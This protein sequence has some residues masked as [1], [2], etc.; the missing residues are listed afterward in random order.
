F[1]TVELRSDVA[2]AVLDGQLHAHRGAVVEGA[3]HVIRVQ[4]L[5]VRRDVDLTGGHR[6]GAGGAQGHA[7]RPFGVHAQGQLLDVQD[8]VDDV[9]PH[10]FQRG[11]FVDDAVDLDGGH[12][13]AL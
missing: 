13:R 2:L 6:A 4:H 1:R 8:D 12:R 3:D 5:D 7:L 11:E 9:F 10:A